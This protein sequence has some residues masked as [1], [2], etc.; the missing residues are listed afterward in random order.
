MLIAAFRGTETKNDWQTKMTCNHEND[1]LSKGKFHSSFVKRANSI[2]IDAILYSVDY[3]EADK[4]IT[5][6]HSL[7]GLCL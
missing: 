2:S 5:Y 3:Y 6:G 4:I 1:F 7:G